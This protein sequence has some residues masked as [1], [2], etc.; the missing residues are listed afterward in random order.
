MRKPVVAVLMGSK[1]DSE[2][3]KECLDILKD[4][5]I[6][7]ESMVC[8]AHRMPEKTRMFAKNASRNGIKVI[9]ACA[10]KAAHL[11]GVVASQTTL[12]VIG[13][14]IKSKVLKGI[15]SFLSTLQMPAGVPVA[16][17]SIG[18]SGAKNAALLAAQ[19]LAITDSGLRK[20]LILYKKKLA[21]LTT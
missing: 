1:S 7:Y 14:P 17:M 6:S 2:V 8:S 20:K 15:D 18:K 11:A 3:V 13:V 5:G 9:I 21:E 4:F 12:P 10:G 19:I 16:A